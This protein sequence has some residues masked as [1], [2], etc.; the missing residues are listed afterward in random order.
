SWFLATGISQYMGGFV[1]TYAAVPQDVTD[2]VKTLPLY[3]H[4]F[5]GLG[6]VAIIGA[7][8]AAAVVPLMKRLSANET[9]TALPA[10]I[11]G[12][13]RAEE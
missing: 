5:Y 3:T 13:I 7:V 10:G 2:P 6:G 8:L 1:A 12:T 9:D 11:P 4:L